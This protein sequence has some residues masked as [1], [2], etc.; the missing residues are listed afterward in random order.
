MVPHLYSLGPEDTIIDYFLIWKV[1]VPH[2]YGLRPEEDAM[3]NE[4]TSRRSLSRYMYILRIIE[5][6]LEQVHVYT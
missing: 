2:L 4:R 5:E 6:V 3:K 1:V